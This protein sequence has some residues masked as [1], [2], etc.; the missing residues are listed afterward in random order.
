MEFLS[1]NIQLDDDLTEEKISS[2]RQKIVD[3][4]IYT[5]TKEI[6]TEFSS[7]IDQYADEN[8]ATLTQ[9]D[10]AILQ[11]QQHKRTSVEELL[12]SVDK[13]SADTEELERQQRYLKFLESNMSR[14]MEDE[15]RKVQE[16]SETADES[17]ETD[18][19]VC[20][21]LSVTVSFIALTFYCWPFHVGL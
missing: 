18:E 2:A 13:V 8:H 12:L 5:T 1:A 20:S 3:A 21:L 7:T 16:K 15:L 19:T 4:L 11:L 10:E 9:M 17:P 14:L 6:S